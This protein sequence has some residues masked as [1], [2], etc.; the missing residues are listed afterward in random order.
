MPKKFSIAPN[1]EDGEELSWNDLKQM[2]YT[3]K[4]VQEMLRMLP[5]G[6]GTFYKVITNIHYDGYKIRF[7][8]KSN[9]VTTLHYISIM[10][11]CIEKL[12]VYG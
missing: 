6:F 9:E 8:K 4:V 3:W 1:K 10:L 5:L 2:K 11:E 12:G 7:L